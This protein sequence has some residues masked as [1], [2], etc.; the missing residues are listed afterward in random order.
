[1][2]FMNEA[3]AVDIPEEEKRVIPKTKQVGT[4]LGVVER[5]RYPV[6]TEKADVVE[7]LA[8]RATFEFAGGPVSE[9][10]GAD[11]VKVNR[12]FMIGL[13][14]DGVP[15]AEKAPSKSGAMVPVNAGLRAFYAGFGKTPRD[16]GLNALI[17]EQTLCY[18]GPDVDQDGKPN[19]FAVVTGVYPVR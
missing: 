2:D 16:C 4:L 7:W 10:F 1:M 19:G 17:G 15:S 5:G 11:T 14:A 8:L 3:F 9:A 18:V 12:D 13:T 6:K